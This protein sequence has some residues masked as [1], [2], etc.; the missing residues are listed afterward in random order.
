MFTTNT[1]NE[2]EEFLGLP[3]KSV[4]SPNGNKVD[5]YEYVDGEAG[6]IGSGDRAMSGSTERGMR[7]T[8]TVL[9]LGTSEILMIPTAMSERSEATKYIYVIY[10]SDDHIMAI[11]PNNYTR[12]QD[13]VCDSELPPNW[14]SE[15]F[16]RD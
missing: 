3:V 2:I 1:R 7:A 8:L 5:L 15:L 13:S 14:R 6:V 16:S 12:K 4:K 11:C 10:A 9:T